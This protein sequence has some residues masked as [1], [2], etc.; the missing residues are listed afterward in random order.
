MKKIL[1][2]AF[3]SEDNFSVTNISEEDSCEKFFHE[4]EFIWKKLKKLRLWKRFCLK[5]HWRIFYPENDIKKIIEDD[6]YRRFLR[7]F[8]FENHSL[9][10][11]LS[12]AW[13]EEDSIKNIFLWRTLLKKL[14]VKNSSLRMNLFGSKF[15]P[16]E[17]STLKKIYEQLKIQK[18]SARL[19][20]QPILISNMEKGIL[21]LVT[22]GWN[23]RNNRDM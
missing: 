5:E 23:L 2:R 20:W 7:R 15:F 11:I 6:F 1:Y 21:T 9:K 8:D 3:Y 19:L 10:N 12:W 22:G 17:T 4:G 16:E 18:N 14:L 13:Y